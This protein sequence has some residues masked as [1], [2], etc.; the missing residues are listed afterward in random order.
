MSEHARPV[1]EDK[2]PT[3]SPL[4]CLHRY[5]LRT[6]LLLLATLNKW[7]EFIYKARKSQT[8]LLVLQFG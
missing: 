8:F 3:R 7:V 2:K 1:G 4:L 6:L 5:Q